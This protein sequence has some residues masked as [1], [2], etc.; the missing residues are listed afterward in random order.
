MRANPIL[1][2]IVLAAFMGCSHV[3]QVADAGSSSEGEGA[4]A[5]GEGEGDPNGEGEG[6]LLGEGEGEGEGEGGCDLTHAGHC[7]DDTCIDL[8]TGY[9]QCDKGSFRRLGPAQCTPTPAGPECATR[10]VPDVGA[11]V[12]KDDCPNGEQR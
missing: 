11:C 9:A 1:L 2:V 10:L 7:A 12:S 6:G 3:P 4:P 5:E 8:G